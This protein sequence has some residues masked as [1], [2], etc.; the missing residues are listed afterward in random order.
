[1]NYANLW[2][3]NIRDAEIQN[4]TTGDVHS[5][6]SNRV[7]VTL[8]NIAPFLEAFGIKAGDKMFRPVE[9]RVIIW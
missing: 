9:E 5:L 1:M 8:K 3:Q 6:G 2:A 7:N 4:L